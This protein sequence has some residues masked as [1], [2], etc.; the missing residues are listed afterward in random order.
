MRIFSKTDIGKTRENNQD[1]YD[2]GVFPDG[3]AWAVV[4]DG[5]GGVSGG[6]VASSICVDEVSKEL[7]NGFN[8]EMTVSD[9]KILLR[10]AVEKA[11][12]AVFNKATGDI[13][14]KGMGTTVVATIILGTTAV[15][16]HVG[17]S[18]AYVA[19][20][21][22]DKFYPVT[23]D[24]SLVQ[25]YIDNGRITEEMAKTHP[26][27][28]IITRAVG[29][30]HR[31]E[32]DFNVVSIDGKVLLICSDGLNGYVDDEDIFSVIKSDVQNSAEKLVEIANLAGGRDNITAVLVDASKGE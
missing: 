21:E 18:R 11:N 24:H 23:K 8:S 13:S 22:N 14:L 5:M 20:I 30:E 28:N 4:C 7:K 16:A 2:C 9:V 26:D 12:T 25:F 15:I 10:N 29:I 1:A 3:N 17:D 6:Q 27:R 19:D 31:V 32:A